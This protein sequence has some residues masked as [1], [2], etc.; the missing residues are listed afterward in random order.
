MLTLPA[1][2]RLRRPDPEEATEELVAVLRRW[3]SLLRAGLPA[4]QAWAET[5]RT[6]PACERPGPTCCAHHRVRRRAA[7]ERLGLRPG[8]GVGADSTTGGVPGVPGRGPGPLRRLRGRLP[9]GG[10]PPDP[11]W[12]L[13]D[14]ALAAGRR[15][16]AAPADVAARL[17]LTLEAAVD[18]ARARRSAAAGPRATARLLQ[19]LPVGGLGMAWL[20]GTSPADLL[21]TPFG[22]LVGVLGLLFAVAGQAW[23]RLLVARATR[24]VGAVEPAVVLDLVAPLLSAGRSLTAA[25]DDLARALPDARPLRAVTTLL[26]WGR[27]WEE[28]WESVGDDPLWG[29][30]AQWLRPLH[31]SGTAGARTLTETAAAVRQQ[32]RRADERGAEELAVQLVMPLSLCL[33][34]SFLCWGVIPMVIA[35]LG[36]GP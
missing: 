22:W 15:A 12:G 18:A 24:P 31:R 2:P 19:W 29:E 23:T 35:L 7:E 1:L 30:V 8:R 20:L 4:D 25:L 11:G 34:P 21:T 5:A 10:E 28:A 9:W 36:S 26:L 17:A 32:A 16:G 13:V 27:P 33:L 6:L 14:T 3:A